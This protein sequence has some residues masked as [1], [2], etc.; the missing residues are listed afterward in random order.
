MA[1]SPVIAQVRVWEVTVPLLDEWAASPVFGAN[2]TAMDDRYVLCITDTEGCEGWGEAVRSGSRSSNDEALS[3]LVDRPVSDFRL[4]FLDL[5]PEGTL[6]WQRPPPPSPYAADPAHLQHRLRHPLQALVEMALGDLTARRTGLPLCALWGG[7]WRDRVPVD[8]WMPRTTPDHAVR[9]VERGKALGFCGVKLKTSLED[10]NVERLEAIQQASADWQVT[11]DA[12]GRFYR[13]DDAMSVLLE[14]DRVGNMAILEDPFPRFHLDEFAELRRRL[15]ARLVVHIDPPE[16]LWNVLT[17]GAAGGLNIDGACGLYNWR[18]QAGAA[19]HANLPVW[20]GSG[21][22]LGIATAAQLHLSASAPNCTLPGDQ[23][24][25]WLRESHLLTRDLRI[26]NGHVLIPEGPGM[27][28]EVDL[29]ALER[30]CTHHRAWPD[31]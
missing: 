28:V 6:Y 8:Y 29:D 27:G 2:P 30:Y 15:N 31:G 4:S 20:Q 9:C 7:A 22:D 12:N 24:G 5:W 19:A 26:E 14:M 18:L 16:S 13:M 23:A 25:P 17:S 10:P 3:G 1:S 21:I 11:V